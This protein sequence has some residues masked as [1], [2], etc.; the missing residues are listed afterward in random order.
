[1]SDP[2]IYTTVTFAPVQGFI[3]KSRKLRDLYGSSYLLSF[4]AQSVCLE[5]KAQGCTVISPA[6]P[7]ITQGLPNQII[8]AGQPGEENI[9][10]ALMKSWQWIVKGCQEWIKDNISSSA[11]YSWNRDWNLWSEH[12]WEFFYVEGQPDESISQ[13][14]QR[15]NEAKR[16]RAWT[17]INWQGESSTLSGADAVAYPDMANVLTT[18][19]SELVKDFYDDLRYQL[20]THFARWAGLTGVSD[21]K[22]REY[23][24]AFIDPK[25][26]LSI[27]EL[28]KRLITHQAIIESLKAR[29]T[30]SREDYDKI[31]PQLDELQK[32]V[33]DDFKVETVSQLKSSIAKDL[34]VSSFRELNRKDG[35][36]W[37]GWFMGDGDGASDYLKWVGK[38]SSESEGKCTQAFSQ[39]MRDWGKNFKANKNHKELS[40]GRIIYAGGD[41]FLGVMYRTDDRLA[42][43]TCLQWLSGFKSQVWEKGWGDPKEKITASVGFVWA[44]PQVPQRDVLQHARLA[45]GSA[46]KAGKDRVAIRVLFAGGNHLEWVCPWRILAEG[47]F[48]KYRDRNGVVNALDKASWTHFYNDVAVLESRHAFGAT[49]KESTEVAISLFD[50]YFPGLRYFTGNVLDEK[51]GDIWNQKDEPYKYKVTK[52]G[53]LGDRKSYIEEDVLNVEKMN[54][55]INEWVINLAKVGFYLC[56]NS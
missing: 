55:S 39:G 43:K 8:I 21:E 4:I 15:L 17:A 44:S 54:K 6:L 2:V 22:I 31:S 29:R 19:N 46:K 41:D 16:Q 30:Y 20:G 35:T 32:V 51:N 14:R 49:L 26:E 5:A 36:E 34:E 38:Q 3:E 50:V 7:D 56:S 23:G 27:P 12:T 28:L 13:V 40:Y 11:P 42:P 9:R 52:A 18:G 37:T 10:N 53:I 48:K 25:E 45:E 1:M 24:A 47:L 33:T